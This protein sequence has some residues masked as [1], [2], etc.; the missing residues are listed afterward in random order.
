MSESR[1]NILQFGTS[2][3]LQAHAD[4]FIGQ[5]LRKGKAAGTITVVQTT[6]SAESA[7]R[8][9]AF[10]RLKTY[11]VVVRGIENGEVVDRREEIGS[12]ER[13]FQADRDWPEI[14]AFFV[15]RCRFVIS[16]TGDRGYLTERSDHLASAPPR[17]FPAKLT[18]LL[19]ARYRVDRAGV[20]FL[21]CE[22]LPDNGSALRDLVCAV[23]VE[24]ALP[25]P[26]VR[27]VRESCVWA[28]SLVDRI[29]SE[30]IDPV[31][32]VAEP[33]ALWAV[34]H[35]PAL[36]LPCE[37]AC[38]QVVPDLGQFELLKLGILNLGHTFLVSRWKKAGRPDI[39]T[40]LDAM[41]DGALYGAWRRVQEEEVLPIFAAMGLEEE[42]RRYARTVDER[43][44]NPFLKHR[45]EDIAGNH[46]QKLQRRIAPLLAR[47]R[48]AAP[49]LKTPLLDACLLG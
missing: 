15:E 16:N 34:Q 5:A 13:A 43:F 2:R 24:W 19:W 46:E 42:A 20:T 11:P 9:A 7:A 29:V 36:E 45:L 30:A 40:V 18:A 4:C 32:A 22:L 8:V 12:I 39:V 38:V 27:W 44:R 23:A 1:S 41:N 37:H 26:F 33:Y 49:G 31:G 17:S 48:E 3:F 10:N 28:N 14:L 21:P 25:E 6:S 47:A 35:Q